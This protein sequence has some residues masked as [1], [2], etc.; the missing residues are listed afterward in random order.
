L[1]QEQ[2]RKNWIRTYE[3]L[4]Y[5]V[6][7]RHY[8]KIGEDSDYFLFAIVTIKRFVDDFK[9]AARD[10]RFTVRK[11]EPTVTIN[12]DKK[13]ELTKQL[14]K[15]K[16]DLKRFCKINYGEVFKSWVHLKAVR[17]YVESVLRFG[18]PARFRAVSI[19]PSPKAEKKIKESFK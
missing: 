6:L 2:K 18:L 13:E 9:A 12:E 11:H 15:R 19:E 5:Y 1:F 3:S 10:K 16:K 8:E 4:T 14:E 17:I 7:P